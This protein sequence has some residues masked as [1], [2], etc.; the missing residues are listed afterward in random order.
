MDFVLPHRDL[1][2]GRTVRAS[3]NVSGETEAVSHRLNGSCAATAQR[4]Q[5][6]G[7]A[8]GRKAE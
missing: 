2:S 5:H 7:W 6:G 1:M 4:L 8:G 3:R